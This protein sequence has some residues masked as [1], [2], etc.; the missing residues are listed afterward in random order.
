MAWNIPEL[1]ATELSA[2]LREPVAAQDQDP[3]SGAVWF[4]IGSPLPMDSDASAEPQR[5]SYRRML[6]VPGG[7]MREIEA[8]VEGA[9]EAFKPDVLRRY[10]DILR[11]SPAGTRDS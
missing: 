8:A 2:I 9:D 1:L 7:L 5:S 4:K 3:M 6:F 11:G 10:A